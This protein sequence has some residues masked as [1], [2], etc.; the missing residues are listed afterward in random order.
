MSISGLLVSNQ[1]VC[2]VSISEYVWM[3]RINSG[4]C[5][6]PLRLLQKIYEDVE[7]LI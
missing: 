1:Y 7:L 3:I 5:P 2:L 6:Y 4:V